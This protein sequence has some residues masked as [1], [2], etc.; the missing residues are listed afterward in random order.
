MSGRIAIAL[1]CAA[2]AVAVLG[3]TP[4][5]SA[6]GSAV[7]V[8]KDSVLAPAPLATAKE[9]RPI[10]GPRGRRG[11]AGRPGPRGPTGQ[12]GAQGERGL[13]GERGPQ[14]ERGAAGTAVAARVR[15]VGEMATSST[16][17]ESERWPLTGN[18]WTQRAGETDMLLGVVEVRNPSACDAPDQ[19]GGYA[20]L[21]LVLDGESIGWVSVGF[22]PGS[23]GRTQKVPLNFY[24]LSGLMAPDSD[25]ARVVVARV[26]DSCTGTEQ[27]FTFKSLKLDVIGAS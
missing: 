5:G 4:L 11:P 18:V 22:Y 25:L 1:S 12:A 10:R 17:Y 6:A 13:Q 7:Q 9:K 15:S 27:N 8:A 3:V 24:P 23:G 26:S 16:P 2:L 19:Y 20:S 14:G 21:N